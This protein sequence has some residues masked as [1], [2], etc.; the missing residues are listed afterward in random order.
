MIWEGARDRGK[1]HSTHSH[2]STPP[3][4]SPPNTPPLCPS[5]CVFLCFL[6]LLLSPCKVAISEYERV[7][8]RSY[9]LF[10]FFFFFLILTKRSLKEKIVSSDTVANH[11]SGQLSNQRK[12]LFP[13]FTYLSELLFFYI[14]FCSLFF[15]KNSPCFGCFVYLK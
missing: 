8:G 12:N 6:Q 15:F 14:F 7:E 2:A 1:G 9:P 5:L 11:P 13:L 10:S 3:S 4:P